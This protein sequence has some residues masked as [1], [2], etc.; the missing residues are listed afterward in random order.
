VTDSLI[1]IPRQQTADE[2]TRATVTAARLPEPPAPADDPS[3]RVAEPEPPAPPASTFTATQ[4]M[5][6][7]CPGCGTVSRVDAGRRFADDFC[8]SCDYPLFW[9]VERVPL[10]VDSTGDGG[11]RRLPGTAG[12]A[13]LAAL[14]CPT[15]TEPN[16]PAAVLC[17]RC[18]SELRPKP[19]V[20][21]VAEPEPVVEPEPEP[22]AGTPW[23][24]YALGLT[25]ILVIVTGVVA[26]IQL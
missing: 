25:A 14:A 12:R 8:R 20:E 22:V 10:P 9:A 3:P 21:V 13:A 17:G 15:C 11:L 19:V 16:P 1:Q 7:T 6:V 5:D 4:V 18:G 26:L 2:A 23:W 24:V